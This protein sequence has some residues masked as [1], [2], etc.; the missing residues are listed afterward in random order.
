M[1]KTGRIIGRP[2]I[3]GRS[4]ILPLSFLYLLP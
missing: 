3:S 2:T 1:N 4:C